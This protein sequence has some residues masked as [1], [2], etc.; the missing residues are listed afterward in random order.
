MSSESE[1]VGFKKMEFRLEVTDDWPPVSSETLWVEELSYGRF[2][3]DNSPFFVRDLAVDDIV[4]G[5]ETDSPFLTFVERVKSGGHSTVWVITMDQSIKETLI[6]SVRRQGCF[7]EV[8]PWP[9]LLSL[10]VPSKRALKDL[11]STLKELGQN[12]DISVVESCLG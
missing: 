3:I 10:D 4:A 5:L 9:S 1:R 11:R 6:E 2:R 12:S 8:S 7:V